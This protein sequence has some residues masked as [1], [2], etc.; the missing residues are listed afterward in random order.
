MLEIDGAAR[1]CFDTVLP[2]MAAVAGMTEELKARD[3]MACICK[4]SA[5]GYLRPSNAV[6]YRLPRRSCG[7][8]AF[9]HIPIKNLTGFIFSH[10]Y[11]IITYDNKKSTSILNAIIM[12]G[13][14]TP[15]TNTIIDLLITSK[16][17]L[18]R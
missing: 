9:A 7:W 4:Y 1:S 2:R 12:P 17:P 3:H 16:Y 15:K 6:Q 8:P 14:V 5:G 18:N 11:L 13:F 10:I